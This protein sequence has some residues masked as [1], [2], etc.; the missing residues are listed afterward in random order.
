MRVPKAVAIAVAALC[1]ASLADVYGQDNSTCD[2]QASEI[3]GRVRSDAQRWIDSVDP[4]LPQ[5]EKDTLGL[6]FS[7]NRDKA[8]AV[9]EQQTQECKA[10]YRDLTAMTDV[11]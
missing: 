8:F 10:R 2:M 7:R 6:L 4:S 3:V 9:I 1:I 11:V 5:S